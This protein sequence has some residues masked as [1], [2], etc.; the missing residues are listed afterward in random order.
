[1]TPLR[2]LTNSVNKKVIVLFY[3]IFI[4]NVDNKLYL[5]PSK[6]LQVI[7]NEQA[8]IRRNIAR[9]TA[10]HSEYPLA[11]ERLQNN[12]NSQLGEEDKC[13]AYWKAATKIMLTKSIDIVFKREFKKAHKIVVDGQHCFRPA[14]FK[15]KGW[16]KITDELPPT[17]QGLAARESTKWGFCSSS[18]K[19]E[20]MKV[21]M[22][23]TN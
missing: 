9:Y 17:P 6:L 1:M 4:G 18:C 20:F 12:G 15:D 21:Y 13:N 14:L 11:W 5:L 8:A 3:G 2:Y 10:C 16:C 7:K 22:M 23:N 19:V